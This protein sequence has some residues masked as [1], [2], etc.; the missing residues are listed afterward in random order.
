[1]RAFLDACVLYAAIGSHKGGSAKI[2]LE[3]K[4]RGFTLVSTN[5]A[6]EETKKNVSRKLPPGALNWLI[7]RVKEAPDV[8]DFVEI[9]SE[10]DVS[11]W[12]AVTVEKDLHVLA[13][14]VR[15]VADVLV[16]LDQKHL[17]KEK[18]REAF[19]IPIMDTKEFWKAIREGSL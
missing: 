6:F 5:I 3:A 15:G 13:G 11:Q 4:E 16:T 10:D 1:M 7:D 14:A 2:I 17:L 12:R 8:W 18:V 19:P 9:I